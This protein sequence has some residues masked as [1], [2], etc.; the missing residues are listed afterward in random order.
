M[1]IAAVGVGAGGRDVPGRANVVRVALGIPM[2]DAPA[3]DS[4][5]VLET[6]VDDMDPRVWPTVLAALLEAG[7]ADAWLVPIVMKKGRPA[8]TLCV[9]T[10]DSEREALR[11][12]VFALTSTIGV[13]ETRVSRVALQ[14]D[15]Q[16]VTLPSGEV[17]IKVALRAGRIVHA[18]PEF[19]DAAA[20]AQARDVPVRQVLDEAT[21][22]ADAAGLRPGAQ[23]SSE[24]GEPQDGA[25][26]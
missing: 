10:H 1:E 9:L 6:N 16:A 17:R 21:A 23:W 8:H 26:I 18:T 20:L 11:D 3:T 24:P 14:R 13:R 4:M 25:A 12:K 15:W 22:A 5:W 7:A 19:A 2:A